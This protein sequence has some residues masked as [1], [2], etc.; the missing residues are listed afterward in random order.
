[1][2]LRSSAAVVPSDWAVQVTATIDRSSPQIHLTWPG[3]AYAK[4]YSVFR[5]S[6][7][8]R[9][10]TALTD[11]AGSAADFVDPNVNLGTGYEYKIVKISTG[12]E[13]TLTYTGYGYIYAGGY[14]P[15]V[16]DRGK[17][18]LLV[19]ASVEPALASEL[20]RFEYDLIGDG[21]TVIRSSVS[22]SD[23]VPAV[24]SKIQAIYAQDPANTRA[25]ILFG[26]VPV[27]Y[28]GDITPDEHP[29]IHQGAWATDVYYADLDGTWTDTT[30]N[31]TGAEWPGNHN[32]PGDGKFDQSEIPSGIELQTGRVDFFHMTCFANKT[33]SVSEV[34]LLRRYLDKDH[35]FRMGQM[36]V[37]QKAII[38]D[39]FYLTHTDPEPISAFAW[40]NYAALTGRNVD[41][42]PWAKYFPMVASKWYLWSSADVGGAAFTIA[43]FDDYPDKPST[44]DVFALQNV[45]AVFC[46]IIGS[47]FGDWDNESNFLRASLGA[48]GGPLTAAYA[49]KPQ[50]LFHHMALGET[51]GFSTKVS[52]EN[53]S[54][55][56]YL[57]HVPGTG[58]V[59]ISL[60]GDPTLRAHPLSPVQ[61]L[62]GSRSPT[63]VTLSWQ[64]PAIDGLQGY[65]VYR[66]SD[67]KGPYQKITAQAVQST[68]MT[69]PDAAPTDV[70]LVKPLALTQTPSGSY[71]NTG[72]GAFYPDPLATPAPPAVQ[73]TSETVS[74]V[75]DTAVNITLSGS[76]PNPAA[77]IY[78]LLS[79]PSNGT[80][81]GTAPNLT[82]TPAPNYNG[83]DS[84]TF[85]VGDSSG[86]SAPATVQLQI[87][88]V[89]DPPSSGSLSVNVGQGLTASFTLPANDVDGN[90]LTYR[91]LSL[92]TKGTLTGNAPNLTYNCAPDGSGSD[93]F[94][95]IVNDG[96]QDSPP[97]VVN[98]QIGT[99]NHPPVAQS[100]AYSTSE[101]TPVTITLAADDSDGDSLLFTVN[102]PPGHGQ[103]TGNAPN[104]IYTPAAQFFGSDSFTYNVTD[105]KSPGVSGAVAIQVSE[106]AQ[107]P[108]SSN[109][110]V[111]T[112]EDQ[113]VQVPI[114][115]T[116][117]GGQALSY[118]LISTPAHGQLAG[119]PP[120]LLYMPATNFT[121]SDSFTYMLSSKGSQSLPAKVQIT[122]QPINHLPAAQNL[123]INAQAGQA[124][125]ITLAATDA[126]GDPLSY[127]IIASPTKGSLTGAGPLFTYT[128][129][130]GMTGADSFT[131]IAKD[132]VSQSSPAMVTINIQR[133][134]HVPNASDATLQTENGQATAITLVGSDADGDPLLYKIATNP[135]QGDLSGT[136]PNLLYTPHPGAEGPDTFSY[137][138]SDG[139]SSS[140]V[141]QVTINNIVNPA[142]IESVELISEG[143]VRLKVQGHPKAIFRIEVSTD[144]VTWSP[145]GVGLCDSAGA[146]EFEDA[147]KLQH[148]K[149]YRVLLP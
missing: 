35:R 91:F 139:V 50:W 52:Q 48:M 38:Y 26:H 81:S 113:A 108:V 11:L 4:S 96:L 10:W 25:L 65:L 2:V 5:K 12:G 138:V 144:G 47:Y 146:G 94:T 68:T 86:D 110:T 20:A 57:P 122:I 99:G 85:A 17:V 140:P 130:P 41:E 51:I 79:N 18:I 16:E 9:T 56:P 58:Q 69:I 92:P 27:P 19:E 42:A 142:I 145:L 54:D 106:Q 76:G 136:A 134:N 22:A 127:Q 95:Y 37:E 141:A 1:M 49:G 118:T 82:Y 23:P 101:N 55:G 67:R 148:I 75:E 3:D 105:G 71:F 34:D 124:S 40:R 64:A 14:L 7:D 93:S 89:N 100:L 24:K 126:D 131:Y 132:A 97:G 98:I 80:L 149:L 120:N 53:G 59:H 72:T 45:N 74:A 36:P 60:L 128:P 109:L 107:P 116:D 30:V 112:L 123:T 119:I 121:G 44:S 117:G 63:G 103:L 125:A 147:T 8:A 114:P 77:L 6:R 46:T 62:R 102:S 29:V 84:F 87:Q 143:L 111:L 61:N 70:F 32:V 15:V 137:T 33:P 135:S 133:Q 115:V 39:A 66:A 90:A 73:A 13:E 21:W 28:S 83:S 129:A 31:D 78:K 104:L 43:Y 88:P